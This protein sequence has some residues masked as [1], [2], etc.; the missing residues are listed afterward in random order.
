MKVKQSR[1]ADVVQVI[2]D[3][4]LAGAERMVEHL[5]IELHR[6]GRRVVVVSLFNRRTPITEELDEAGVPV[7]FLNKNAGFDRA[8]IPAL[9]AVFCR[10]RPRV[11]HTHRHCMPY[12]LIAS[13]GLGAKRVHT[14]HNLAEREVPVMTRRVHAC[15]YKLGLVTPVAISPSVLRS[16]CEGY[17]LD[18]ASIPLVSNGIPRYAPAPVSDCPLDPPVFTFLNIGRAMEQKNQ[19]A[20]I[21]AFCRFHAHHPNT[22]LLIIGA[23]ELFETMRREVERR[24]AHGFITLLG[25]LANA[26]DYYYAADAFVLP[27]LYEGLPLTLIEAMM[28]GIPVLASAVGGS[29]DI[30]QD[31]VTGYS[32]GT[33]VPE[34]EAGLSRLYRDPRRREVA[35]AGKALSERYTVE[36]MADGYEEVYGQ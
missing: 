21:A 19:I 20:L 6:R 12:A 2:P 26:R 27:S 25:S 23:G 28:A 5:S 9:R 24:Q 18:E 35:R 8:V 16:V 29:V 30:V 7:V 3:L 36:A 1:V 14:V 4:G 32:C 22:R 15:A 31:G 10:E 13:M 33:T 11:I 17:H 34:I